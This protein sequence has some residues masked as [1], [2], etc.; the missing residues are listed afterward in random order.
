M[1]AIYSLMQNLVDRVL[2]VLDGVMGGN[3]I[4]EKLRDIVMGAL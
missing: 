1:S 3:P 4:F 2:A